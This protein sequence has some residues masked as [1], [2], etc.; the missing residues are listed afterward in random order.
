MKIERIEQSTR[1][2]QASKAGNLVI[3]AGQIGEGKTV[4][5]Q[6]E[7]MFK[8][9]DGLLKKAGGSKANVLY[10]NIFLTDMGDYEAFNKVWDNWVASAE[11]QTPSRAAIQ[12]V[13]LAKPEWKVEV[14]VF[15]SV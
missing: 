9:I 3:L 11:G 13:K 2:S 1:M 5:E 4:T 15:A 7:S 6:A 8:S 12:V 10:A 14:Q